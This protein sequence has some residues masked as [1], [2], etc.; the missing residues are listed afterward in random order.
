LSITIAICVALYAFAPSI[1]TIFGL[2]ETSVAMGTEQ[3]RFLAPTY[4]IFAAYMTLGGVLQGAGDTILQSI[5]TLTAL[6]L[7]VVL[8]YVGV[9][10]GIMG[11]AAAWL[12]L[13][14]GW[15]AAIVITNVRY[16]T[17]GWKNKAI[18]RGVSV[19][20]PEV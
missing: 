7:R 13:P 19:A 6:A 20:P 17:G 10:L 5:A 11:Y 2:T 1:V 16:Y 3:I 18:T 9:S 14:I 15:F 12:T 8:G 4:W